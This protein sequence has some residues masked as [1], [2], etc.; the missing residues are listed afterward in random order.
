MTTT[1]RPAAAGPDLSAERSLIAPYEREHQRPTGTGVEPAQVGQVEFLTDPDDAA[2]S[3]PRDDVLSLGH[4]GL[5][6][7]TVRRWTALGLSLML[8]FALGR[9]PGN[10]ASRHTPPGGAYVIGNGGRGDSDLSKTDGTASVLRG[11]SAADGGYQCLRDTGGASGQCN[12]AMGIEHPGRAR[13]ASADTGRHADTPYVIGINPDNQVG[14]YDRNGRWRS[15]RGY[16]TPSEAE[17]LTHIVKP[18]TQRLAG[19]PAL[20]E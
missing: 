4:D 19:N 18:A 15:Y 8:G 16:V 3:P 14:S 10:V 11:G 1:T 7:A 2:T 12:V 5:R 13:P 17:H 20:H 9:G 6:A